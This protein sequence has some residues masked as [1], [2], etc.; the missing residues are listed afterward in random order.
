M[1]TFTFMVNLPFIRINQF[2][3]DNKD[4]KHL[5]K[6]LYTQTLFLKL[7]AG[8][9]VQGVKSLTDEVCDIQLV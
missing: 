5:K 2:K 6:T 3:Y 4:H 7:A 8:V 1:F 9:I